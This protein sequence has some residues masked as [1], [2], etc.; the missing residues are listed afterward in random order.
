[1]GGEALYFGEPC[2]DYYAV[3]TR[4]LGA[5]GGDF[6]PEVRNLPLAAFEIF[7]F[8]PVSGSGMPS[9]LVLVEAINYY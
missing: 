7:C 8:I 9:S 4:E 3:L 6:L 2:F 5:L 1:L